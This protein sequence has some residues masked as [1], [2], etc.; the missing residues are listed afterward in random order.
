MVLTPARD[1][2]WDFAPAGSGFAAIVRGA[3]DALTFAGRLPDG[4]AFTGKS[5]VGEDD[6][7][8]L[9]FKPLAREGSALGG[10]IQAERFDDAPVAYEAD[11]WI[12][13]GPG[14]GDDETAGGFAV[15]CE[16]WVRYWAVPGGASG[17]L[18]ELLVLDPSRPFSF[19][20]DIA[21]WWA[22]EAPS[23][24]LL[25]RGG[26]VRAASPEQ[27]PGFVLKIDPATGLF[28]GSFRGPD[29]R[30]RLVPHAFQGAMLQLGQSFLDAPLGRGFFHFRIP[31]EPG[32][33]QSGS[34]ELDW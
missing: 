25:G 10:S 15:V 23:E 27:A 29:A 20:I 24:L 2:G 14:I 26:V 5:G 6:V 32:V 33:R 7:H 30:E 13:R 1:M 16:S 17:S 9:F 31:D 11:E 18:A 4:T 19:F 28:R 8:R 34:V 21:S 22:P 12:W 3:N